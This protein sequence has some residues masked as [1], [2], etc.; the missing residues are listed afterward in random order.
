M[1]KNVFLFKTTTKTNRQ[2]NWFKYLQN[3]SQNPH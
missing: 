3:M 1:N 2:Q